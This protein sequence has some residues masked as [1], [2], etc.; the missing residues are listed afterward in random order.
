LILELGEQVFAL[1][2]RNEE[3]GDTVLFV[4]NAANETVDVDLP[5]GGQDLWSNEAVGK[6]VE[7]APYQ[8]M[9]IKK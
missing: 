8:F 1:V 9:W 3:T 6:T 2:R 4:V 5:F 7:L